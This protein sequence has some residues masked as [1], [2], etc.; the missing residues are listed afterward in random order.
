MAGEQSI[1]WPERSDGMPGYCAGEPLGNNKDECTMATLLLDV[2]ALKAF[3]GLNRET[4]VVTPDGA[5]AVVNT[6]VH[7]YERLDAECEGR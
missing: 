1:S 6:I 4:P 7:Y 3:V 2:K 5:L